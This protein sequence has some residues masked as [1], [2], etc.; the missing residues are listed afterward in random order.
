[1][2]RAPDPRLGPAPESA[3]RHLML[4]VRRAQR[5]PADAN[6]RIPDRPRETRPWARTPRVIGTSSGT[7]GPQSMEGRRPSPGPRTLA[8]SIRENPVRSSKASRGRGGL[9]VARSHRQGPARAPGDPP[10]PVERLRIPYPSTFPDASRL[11]AREWGDGNAAK[12]GAME[13]LTPPRC[14]PARRRVPTSGIG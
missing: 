2:S 12:R 5:I 6:G 7:P 1:M 3:R 11:P 8:A 10:E 13:S 9:P 4:F 14:K